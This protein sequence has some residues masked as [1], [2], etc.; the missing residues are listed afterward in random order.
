MTAL[1]GGGEAA[2]EDLQDLQNAANSCTVAHRT[3]STSSVAPKPGL[4]AAGMATG[5]PEVRRRGRT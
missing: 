2:G 3:E 5:W 1:P 4:E